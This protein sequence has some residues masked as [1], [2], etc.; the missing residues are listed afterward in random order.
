MYLPWI[1][2]E[3]S[4]KTTK[5]HIVISPFTE[6]WK[7]DLLNTKKKCLLVGYDTSKKHFWYSQG[8]AL[9]LVTK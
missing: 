5:I 3:E 2:F 4:G 8:Q 9:F 1:F 6:I 7:R